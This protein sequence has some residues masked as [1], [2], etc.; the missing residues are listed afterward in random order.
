VNK[1]I[2]PIAHKIGASNF[3]GEPCIVANQLKTLIPV[4]T[5]IT[6]VAA[7]K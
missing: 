6:I 1:K 5:A 4:G 7:V 2:N 3:K